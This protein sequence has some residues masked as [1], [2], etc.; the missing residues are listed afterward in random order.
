MPSSEYNVNITIS[1][2][3]KTSGPAK[4]AT[5]SVNNLQKAVKLL[6]AGW[7]AV[8]TA[9]AVVELTKLGAAAQ[10]QE[11]ALDNLATAAGSSGDAILSSIQEASQ[12]TIDRMGAMQTANRALI[13]GVAETPE[14]FE[15]LTT[16]AVALGRA[17]GVDA[18]TSIDNFVTAAGRQSYM[19]A[20]NLGLIVRAEEAQKNYADQIGKTAT[21]LTLQEKRQAFLNEML[22]QGEAK[23]GAL[24]DST[25]D[26]AA[27][28]EQASAAWKDFK[29]SIGGMLATLASGSGILQAA[30]TW[31][32]NLSAVARSIEEHGF[33]IQG[34]G[35]A[36]SEFVHTLAEG[37]S[38]LEASSAAVDQ[39]AWT[40]KWTEEATRDL[41]AQQD[42]LLNS[43]FGIANAADDATGSIRELNPEI[44][45]Y[46]NAIEESSEVVRYAY[47]T[48]LPSMTA[49][50]GD[51]GHAHVVVTDSMIESL[52]ILGGLDDGMLEYMDT[53]GQA[54]DASSGF[55]KY[56]DDGTLSLQ[57]MDEAARGAASAHAS[58]AETLMDASAAEIAS[59]AIRQLTGLL[60]EGKISAEDYTMAVEE[61]QLE[62]GLASEASINLSKRLVELV[63]RT[64]E[65]EVSAEDFKEELERL[66]EVN[67][68]EN[69]QLEQFGEILYEDKGA[70]DDTSRAADGFKSS[71]DAAG[72]S[73]ATAADKTANLSGEMASLK[74]QANQAGSA[75][76]GVI[77]K[78]NAMPSEKRIRIIYELGNRPEDIP[79]QHGGS[80]KAGYPYLVGERG[81][82]MFVPGSSGQIINNSRTEQIVGSNNTY[83][84]PDP[85]AMAYLGM[86]ERARARDAFAYRSG[87]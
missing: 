3:D 30:S 19:I 9:Q 4:A 75:L 76:Q 71:V 47:T 1:T 32:Q 78:L 36:Y 42:V 15:R 49:A 79:K 56:V 52:S 48:D 80:V 57:E 44:D 51:V 14:Q 66:I 67:K 54:G 17:M 29:T 65:G 8:K 63:K 27:K 24:G 40:A 60:D 22:V 16:V 31:A 37:G 64:G 39:Y 6:A 68:L 11:K 23:M 58:L 2:K 70:L 38:V 5:S 69:A 73:A 25:L 84:F 59:A 72:S 7:A 35:K 82:E 21:E 83:N 34:W 61:T 85:R 10:R 81:P 18:V 28:I 77:D 12:F 55:T 53:L 74:S 20:D 45:R 43:Y 26:N 62:F 87:M 86:Q 50:L 46:R 13:M 41:A 33:S